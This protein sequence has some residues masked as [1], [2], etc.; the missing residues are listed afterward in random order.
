MKPLTSGSVSHAHDPP[1]PGSSKSNYDK[2]GRILTEL[3]RFAV[4]SA[5]K[6]ANSERLL[7]LPHTNL[8][9][10][11]MRLLYNAISFSSAGIAIAALQTK[12]PSF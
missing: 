5:Q 4:V 9:S 1:V 10:A 8:I 12:M 6:I 11:Q 3:G 2:I 7:F